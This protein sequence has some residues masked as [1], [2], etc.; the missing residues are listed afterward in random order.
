MSIDVPLEEFCQGIHP[1]GP[2]WDHCLGYWDASLKNP[3]KVLFLKYEDLKKDI[4]SSVKKIA[5]FLG[6]PFSAE[7]EEAGF[8]EEIAML[9]SFENLK[10]LDCNK[11]GEIHAAYRAKHSSFFRKAEV[12]DWV[13]VLTPSM[14][15]RLENL[16]Q[17]KLGES[18][19]TLEIN[20][21]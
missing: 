1:Y 16:F 11:E 13:N 21:N 9:C 20:S 3:Q 14:A 10:N 12:G 17:E 6:Y 18:G 8:V 4:N 15:N 19:L 5:D 2:L 7:E